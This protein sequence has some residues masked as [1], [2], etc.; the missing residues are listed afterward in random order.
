MYDSTLMKKERT[1]IEVQQ[2]SRM[3]PMFQSQYNKS[4]QSRHSSLS[5][6]SKL[7]SHSSLSRHSSL[8]RHSSLSRYFVILTLQSHTFNCPLE[9]HCL[10]QMAF[11]L[12]TAT[13]SQLFN[14]KYQLFIVSSQFSYELDPIELHSYSLY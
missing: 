6:C 12:M 9:Y 10:L 2:F 11:S 7:L 1:I 14:A 13:K 5:R 3:M 8:T 4:N